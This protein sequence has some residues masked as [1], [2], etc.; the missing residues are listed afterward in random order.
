VN[1]L[2]FL[3]GA[4][5]VLS[6]QVKSYMPFIFARF[7]TGI[8]SGMFTGVG[9]LYL[10]EIAPRNLRGAA[11]TMHQLAI[12]IGILSSN[13]MGLPSVFG[14]IELWPYLYAITLIPWLVHF[15]FLPFCVET[16]KYLFIN[17]DD[18]RETEKGKLKYRST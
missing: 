5:S 11:G 1:A 9:P 15:I 12:V 2:V 8:T 4:L 3:S 13:I 14:T 10:S 18:P 7:L 6:V 17:R 16:P